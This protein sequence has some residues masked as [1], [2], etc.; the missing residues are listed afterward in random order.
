MISV[1][2]PTARGDEALELVEKALKRQTHKDFEWIVQKKTPVK[3]GNVWSLNHD[4]NVAIKK[5][6]GELIISFQDWTYAD[7]DCLEKFWTH[8]KQEPKT[9]VS[10]VGNK[11]KDDTWREV[12]WQDPRMREDQGTWYGCYFADIEF[13]LS[14][15]PR[16]AFYAIGGFDEKLDRYFGMDGYGVAD[17]LNILG[18][19][20][21]KLDQTIKS[22]SLEHGRPKGWEKHNALHGPYQK[23]RKDYVVNPVLPYLEK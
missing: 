4:Y 11:Y 10:A 5:A 12:V 8:Y 18:G 15:V 17:R 9:L 3:E 19:Y 13:N 22:Y 2:T 21:F 7:P 14:A 20:D 6:K 1:I 23:R 16:E